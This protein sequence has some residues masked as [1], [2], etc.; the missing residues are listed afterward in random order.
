[1]HGGRGV[2][3]VDVATFGAGERVDLPRGWPALRGAWDGRVL[4]IASDTYGFA[5]VELAGPE[6]PRILHPRDRKIRIRWE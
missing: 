3:P 4:W 6:A 1:M 5:A 2:T